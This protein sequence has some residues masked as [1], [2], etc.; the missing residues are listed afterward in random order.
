M[1]T[2]ITAIPADNGLEL[3]PRIM[4]APLLL[5]VAV[6]DLYRQFHEAPPVYRVREPMVALLRTEMLNTPDRV[7]VTGSART[8][9]T[10]VVDIEIR[11]F[12]GPL[13]ANDPWAAVI[14]VDLGSLE[15][16]RYS[17]E[18]Y[19]TVLRFMELHHPERAT[20]PTTSDVRMSFNCV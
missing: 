16:G 18:M 4:V 14:R 3:R 1:K 7:A 5:G 9:G 8:N 13:A 20:N 17:I 19:E 11:R 10:F 2:D 6:A 12:D 15:Q